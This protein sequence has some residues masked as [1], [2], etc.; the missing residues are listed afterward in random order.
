MY[1]CTQTHTHIQIY[2]YVYNTYTVY[3]I[4][5]DML[6]II[7]AIIPYSLWSILRISHVWKQ[8]KCIHLY[9]RSLMVM[10][11]TSFVTIKLTRCAL[12]MLMDVLSLLNA[13]LE[14]P[15]KYFEN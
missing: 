13:Y 15:S 2:M 12:F 7:Y 14:S 4:F 10:G 5:I 6:C 3:I 1:M 9:L 8:T 11:I